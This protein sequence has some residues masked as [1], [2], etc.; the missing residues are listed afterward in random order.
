M[1][2]EPA[3]LEQKVVIKVFWSWRRVGVAKG[4]RETLKD[5]EREHTDARAG[6]SPGSSGTG[7]AKSGKGKGWWKKDDPFDDRAGC[8]VQ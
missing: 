8:V 3:E 1:T 6:L 4:W 7:G 5:R 2:Y